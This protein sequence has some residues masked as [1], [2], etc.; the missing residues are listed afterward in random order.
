MIDSSDEY[1]ILCWCVV[2]SKGGLDVLG[3]GVSRPSVL[4]IEYFAANDT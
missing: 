2:Y 3:G 4:Q 1:L